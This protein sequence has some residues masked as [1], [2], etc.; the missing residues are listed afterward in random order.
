MLHFIPKDTSQRLYSFRNKTRHKRHES[1]ILWHCSSGFP[2][3]LLSELFLHCRFLAEL[4]DA[5]AE[6]HSGPTSSAWCWGQ[7]N[8]STST[9]NKDVK[10]SPAIPGFQGCGKAWLLLGTPHSHDNRRLRSRNSSREGRWN[11][12]SSLPH[13]VQASKEVPCL[14]S[15]VESCRYK[16][17]PRKRTLKNQNM[18]QASST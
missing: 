11:V 2:I 6:W 1:L 13:P 8:G 17:R 18:H 3:K 12:R 15:S 16:S 14:A 10:R 5:I 4:L 9:N 7:N